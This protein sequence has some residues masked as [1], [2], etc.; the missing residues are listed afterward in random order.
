MI[1]R[2]ILHRCGR[3]AL[4]ISKARENARRRD[5]FSTSSAVRWRD[6]TVPI[7]RRFHHRGWIIQPAVGI[8]RENLTDCGCIQ[9]IRQ[10]VSP[11]A[12]TSN[13]MSL[14]ICVRQSQ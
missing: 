8:I 10:R 3:S 2:I 1:T 7:K 14:H 4:A 12:P 11:A 9:R 13:A 5:A 6:R